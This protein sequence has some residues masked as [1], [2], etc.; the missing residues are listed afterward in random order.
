VPRT[1]EALVRG[2][3]TDIP[4]DADI[5]PFIEPANF[6][7][8]KL[9]ASAVIPGTTTLWYADDS[10]GLTLIETWLAAHFCTVDDPRS[11]SE[12]VGPIT[13]RLQGK[14]DLGLD[15]SLYGQNAMRLDISGILSRYN[16]VAK[17]D[18]RIRLNVTGG[19]R[20]LGK[21]VE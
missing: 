10:D 13:Q 15:S 12:K 7:V 8:T 3:K 21:P 9:L 4:D 6:L 17:K 1:T 20:W 5:D 11:A 19:V 14:I 16:N 18:D 2:I